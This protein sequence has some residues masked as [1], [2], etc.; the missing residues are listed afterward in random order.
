VAINK[1]LLKGSTVILVLTLL[2]H[3]DMYGYEIVKELG[4]QS[5]GVFELKEGT[6]YPI[7]HTLEGEQWV[8]AYWQEHDGRKRKYYR[9][10]EDG[11]RRLKEK[12]AEWVLF[13]TAVDGVIGEGGR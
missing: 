12:K 4:R 7:L 8:H 10:T 9:I 13:R 6:L 11:R 5:D 2:N 3:R 1:E